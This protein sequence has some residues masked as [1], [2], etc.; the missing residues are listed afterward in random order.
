MGQYDK[1]F[2]PIQVGGITIPNRIVRAPHGTH[3]AGEGLIAYHEARA[4]GGVGMSTVQATSVHPSAPQGIRLF[5]DSCMPFLEELTS[6]V[7]KHGM[8]IFH[9][10]YHPGAGYGEAMNAAEHWSASEIP[11]PMA[12][13]V[14]IAITQTQIEDL[15]QHFANAARRVRD[16]GMDGVDIHASSGYLIHEFLSPALNKRTDKYGGSPENRLRLLLDVITAVRDA[17]GDRKFAVGVRL[18]NEDYVPGGLNPELVR[19]IAATVDP[20]VDYVS[21]HMG[22]YWRFHKLIAPSDDPLG[23]EM[24]ANQAIKPMITKPT[25]VTGRIMT[26]DHANHIVSSGEADMVSMVRALIADPELVNKAK[27]GEEH[28]IRPCIGSNMGCVG[29]LM[30]GQGLSCVVNVAAAMESKLSQE[31]QSPTDTPKKILVVGGGPAGLE[32]ARTAAIRGHQVQLHEAMKVLGGQ[33]NM[34]AGAPHRGDIG[35]ITSWLI[36][37]LE[38]LQVDTRLNSLVDVD[39]VREAAPDEVV[40]ATGTTPRS[41]GFQLTDPANPIPGYNLPNV[42]NSWDLFGFGAPVNIQGPALVYDDT[43]SFEAISVA[44][45]LL[46]AG[47]HVTMV[48]RMNDIGE[49]LPFPPVTVGAAKERLM[50]GNFDF[51]GGHYLREIRNGEV[52]VGVM[53]TE[54]CRTLPARTII[55]VGYNE[56]NR[57]LAEELEA[58]G[59]STHQIGDVQG[60][61]NIRNAIHSGALLGRAI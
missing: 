12:G 61:N 40:I 58:A 47:V 52:D 9:Q 36:D 39:L 45:V 6:R 7:H 42:R 16:C 1:L 32:F 46:A 49:N 50:S 11:N 60:R 44:D 22:A 48:S 56:P 5:E 13:V 3:L 43:G 54:R 41:D 2:E 27:R 18:P 20:L 37:E 10:I 28:R 55:I 19:G 38:Y 26:M 17:V 24:V 35:A 34:A 53:F 4:K 23:V 15:V 59:I 29:R 14:P 25:I 30:S 57:H 33:V 21:L 51:I 31:P 8:K